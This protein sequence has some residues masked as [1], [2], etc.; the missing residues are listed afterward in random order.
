[1][2]KRKRT[3]GLTVIYKTLRRKLKI[4]PHPVP[5]L[6]QMRPCVIYFMRPLT[7][8]LKEVDPVGLHMQSG[9]HAQEI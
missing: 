6:G 1:V 9:I 8:A 7:W 3:N 2:D 5:D 4:E